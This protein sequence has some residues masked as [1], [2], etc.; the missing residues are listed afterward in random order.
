[1]FAQAANLSVT[2]WFEILC[3]VPRSGNVLSARTTFSVVIPSKVEESRL[4]TQLYDRG[5]L[6]LRYTPLRMT[7]RSGPANPAAAK[8]HITVVNHRSLPRCHSAL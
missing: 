8:N 1:M 5:I 2:S 4:A 3:A 7:L 6:R